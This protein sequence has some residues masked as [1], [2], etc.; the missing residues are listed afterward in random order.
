[1]FPMSP[2]AIKAFDCEPGR[3]TFGNST[4]T[5]TPVWT[6]YEGVIALIDDE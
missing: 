4:T 5:I 2:E 6:I 3:V 1:M